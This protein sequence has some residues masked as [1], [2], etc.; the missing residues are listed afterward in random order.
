MSNID[1]LDDT[2]KRNLVRL[3]IDHILIN[4]NGDFEIYWSF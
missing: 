3:L 4:P 1:E 2:E